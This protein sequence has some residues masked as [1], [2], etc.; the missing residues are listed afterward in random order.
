VRAGAEEVA[1]DAPAAAPAVDLG[2]PAPAAVLAGC[3]AAG[4]AV[5]APPAGLLPSGP[6]SARPPAAAVT[7]LGGERYKVQFT[8]SRGLRDKLTEAQDLLGRAGPGGDL[9]VVVERAL[10]ALLK[11]L[12]RKKYGAAAAPRPRSTARRDGRRTRHVPRATRRAVVTRDGGRCAYVDPATGKRCTATTGLQFHHVAPWAR[13]GSDEPSNVV[14]HC[15]CHNGL[16]AEQ[17]FGPEL[18]ARGIARASGVWRR[19]VAGA[20]QGRPAA[21]GAGRGRPAAGAPAGQRAANADQGRPAA[22][23]PAG[24][25]AAT[26]GDE[27][28]T[29]QAGGA[30]VAA[31]GGGA[32]GAL[33]AATRAGGSAAWPGV[34]GAAAG[35]TGGAE[36]GG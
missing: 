29:P 11:E 7:P 17:A 2:L 6:V 8:A 16:L 32:R 22:D 15:A 21:G 23:A 14:L 5:A 20:R 36:P 24:Q 4:M 26:A 35:G 28:P 12:R 27:R 31:R 25:R 18:V 30:V 9:A 3:E 34:D 10:E 19:A 1:R 33:G 13:G